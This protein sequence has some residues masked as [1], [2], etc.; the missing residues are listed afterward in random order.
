MFRRCL[1]GREAPRRAFVNAALFVVCIAAAVIAMPAAAADAAA[2]VPFVSTAT[3]VSPG[4][5]V[6]DGTTLTVTYNEPPV[7][8]S[9][10]SLTLTDGSDVGT[11]STTAGSLT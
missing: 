8:A 1:S 3:S 5:A 6:T 4:A 11:L 2:P 9:S 10:Y 7:L